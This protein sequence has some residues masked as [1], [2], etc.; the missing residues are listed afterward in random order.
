MAISTNNVQSTTHLTSTEACL[1]A[2]CTWTSNEDR[3]EKSVLVWQALQSFLLI[4]AQCIHPLRRGT[5]A[6]ER[7]PGDVSDF[8]ID[9]NPPA[10]AP[11]KGRT[12]L[13]TDVD[14]KFRWLAYAAVATE[15][16]CE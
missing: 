15:Q 8:W 6:T 11:P 12:A 10:E 2:V 7:L 1:T 13:N 9:T 4:V 16:R 5:G 3:L 14:T